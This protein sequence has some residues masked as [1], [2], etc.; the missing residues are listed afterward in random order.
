MKPGP[1]LRLFA[2]CSSV[3]SN[4]GRKERQGLGDMAFQSLVLAGSFG[5]PG[6]QKTPLLMFENWSV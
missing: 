2:C 5:Y 1:S 3:S 4:A 6:V